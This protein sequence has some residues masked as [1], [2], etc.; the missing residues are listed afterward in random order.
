ME[1]NLKRDARIFNSPLEAG[2][3]ALILLNEMKP[4]GGLDLQHIVVLDYILTHSGDIPDGPKSLHADI[5]HRASAISLRRKL[6]EAGLDLLISRDLVVKM[7]SPELGVTYNVSEISEK[8]LSYFESN[9]F[10]NLVS[11]AKWINQNFGETSVRLP[12]K[13]RPFVT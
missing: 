2:L 4:Q 7:F 6:L 1:E 9:H 5:P 11:R 13:F 3:R 8:F 10:L 12:S